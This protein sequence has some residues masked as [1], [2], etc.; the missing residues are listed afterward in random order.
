M[1]LTTGRIFFW[2]R[3]VYKKF[4]CQALLCW[5]TCWM[6]I[7]N[8]IVAARNLPNSASF[9]TLPS[10]L[11]F[12]TD[13]S[14]DPPSW[15]V[16]HHAPLKLPCAELLCSW[17]TRLFTRDGRPLA[18]SI[19]GCCPRRSGASAL[20][21]LMWR[22]KQSSHADSDMILQFGV[23]PYVLEDLPEADAKDIYSGL[24][25][26]TD[27]PD[28]AAEILRGHD[29][30]VETLRKIMCVVQDAC[31]RFMDKVDELV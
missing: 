12:S 20:L 19:T 23:K 15:L 29:E 10:I 30:K 28:A 18:G 31:H 6:A 9:V 24:G 27:T 14:V 11:S 3:K 4:D 22:L 26:W 13:L 25:N 17:L 1:I 16:P 2:E 21:G 5:L 7:L 8:P